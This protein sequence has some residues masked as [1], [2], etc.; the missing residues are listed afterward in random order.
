M[1][2]MLRANAVMDDRSH[3]S[4]AGASVSDRQRRRKKAHDLLD[5]LL[6]EAERQGACGTVGVLADYRTGELE[7]VREHWA[8]THK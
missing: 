1:P 6:N 8:V 3:A 5:K 4:R 2:H 7:L